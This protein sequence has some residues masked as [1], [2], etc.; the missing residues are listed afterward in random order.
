MQKKVV[1]LG[2]GVTGLVTAYE[3]SKESKNVIVLEK[4]NELGGALRSVRI[5]NS[6]IERYY[7]HVFRRD[8]EFLS[9]LKELGIEKN[10]EWRSA[11]TAFLYEN[12][13]YELS[14]PLDLLSFRPLTLVNRLRLVRTLLKIKTMKDIERYDN[15]SPKEWITKNSGKDV[16]DNFFK[17]LLKSKYGENMN[18]ISSAWFIDR[19]RLRSDRGLGGEVLGYYKGGFQKFIDE[20]E[21]AIKRNGC[22]ILRNVSIKKIEVKNNRIKRVIY[23]NKSI[24]VNAMISTIPPRN[25]SEILDTNGFREELKKIHYQGTICVLL[26]LDIKLSDF[27]W[28]NIIRDDIKFG[29]IVEH[30]NFQPYSGYNSHIVY[31]GS[32]P[33]ANSSLWKLAE[34]EIFILY[35]KD[36]KKIFP[37]I[38]ENNVKWWKVF[39]DK[40]CGLVYEKGIKSRILDH[41]TPIE[42]LFIGGMFN[43]YPDRNINTSVQKGKICADLVKA[44]I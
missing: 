28:V 40:N 14:S 8:M 33:D 9:L 42:N 4:E 12:G 44:I 27:Y 10:F 43:S 29:A 1:I 22:K 13:F 21:K 19:I 7:H 38:K 15:T 35:F 23:N 36:L 6:F 31:L 17:P 30:T 16:F 32:Y 18:S 41:T 37:S 34:K 25:L 3:L 5:G 24:D 26:G 20:L 11:S 39:K 2:A